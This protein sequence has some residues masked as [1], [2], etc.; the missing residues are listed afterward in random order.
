MTAAGTAPS[1]VIPVIMNPAAGG[2]RPLAEKLGLE[3]AARREGLHLEWHPTDGPGHASE[4]ARRLAREERPLVLAMGGDGTYN[5]VARGLVGSPTAMGILP[6]GTTAVLAYEIGLPRPARRALGV[7]VNG[8]NAAMRV[9][10]T[11]RGDLVLLMLSAGPDSTVLSRVPVASKLRAGKLAIAYQALRELLGRRRFATFT[12]QTGGDAIEAG[13]VIIGK[14][15]RY[16]GPFRATPA[17]DPFEPTLEA[18]A[19]TA[20]GR[21]AALAFAAALIRDRHVCRR[22]VHRFVGTSFH[23][24]PGRDGLPVPYQVDGDVMG[25]LPVTVTVAE[26]PLLLRVPATLQSS[27]PANRSVEM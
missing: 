27:R 2:G 21:Q 20:S 24:E 8:R 11:D 19:Q 15:Q 1:R 13:W 18:V 3:S 26:D 4:I 5:E 12:L 6:A 17:A 7:L 25:H 10:H 9:A 22:D 14:S 16:A 23:L